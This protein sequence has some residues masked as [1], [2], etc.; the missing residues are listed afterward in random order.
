MDNKADAGWANF[1]QRHAKRYA[2]GKKNKSTLVIILLSFRAFKRKQKSN[3]AF[4]ARRPFRHFSAKNNPKDP[5]PQLVESAV[6]AF[7]Q[8]VCSNDAMLFTCDVISFSSSF[9]N[10]A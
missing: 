1:P 5:R 9:V 10:P 6:D 3:R 2:S 7:W 8:T 4:P